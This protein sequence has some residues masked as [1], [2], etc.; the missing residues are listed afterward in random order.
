MAWLPAKD[1]T[2]IGTLL[3]E[4]SEGL[5]RFDRA[6]RCGIRS[7][8]CPPGQAEFGIGIDADWWGRGIAQEAA[9]TILRV[10]FLELDLYEIHGAPFLATKPSRNSCG[11]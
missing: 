7:K 5:P 10:G 4:N 2:P 8:D 3:N 11:G 1:P 6:C 9:T